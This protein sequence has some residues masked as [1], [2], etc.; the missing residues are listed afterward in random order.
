MGKVMRIYYNEAMDELFIR[1]LGHGD[2]SRY[3]GMLDSAGYLW[4][5]KSTK[6]FK[7]IGRL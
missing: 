5:T 1:V 7:Y 2:W 4:E 6:R 3:S